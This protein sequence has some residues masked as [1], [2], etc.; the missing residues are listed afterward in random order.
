M[1]KKK[2]I[3]KKKTYLAALTMARLTEDIFAI[4]PRQLSQNQ[5]QFD[6]PNQTHP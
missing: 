5:L 6:F 1:S 3:V 4:Y 2:K